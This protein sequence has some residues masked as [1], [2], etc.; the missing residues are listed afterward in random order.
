MGKRQEDSEC[1]QNC[2][3]SATHVKAYRL[4]QK[5]HKEFLL[6]HNFGIPSKP[7]AMTTLQRDNPEIEGMQQYDLFHKT[8]KR[9]LRKI[10]RSASQ[11]RAKTAL[12]MQ[13]RVA[14]DVLV[15]HKPAKTQAATLRAETALDALDQNRHLRPDSRQ[16]DFTTEPSRPPSRMDNSITL[17]P[18][19]FR[20][21]EKKKKLEAQ[22]SRPVT[23]LG[24]SRVRNTFAQVRE[25][26]EARSAGE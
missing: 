10:D 16:T 5:M 12:G 7:R 1:E 2:A 18:G 15:T 6:S 23:S 25:E 21:Y 11:A 24:E 4:K 8:M 17:A 13:R 3:K 26:E 9:T 22:A 14:G 20:K 19:M